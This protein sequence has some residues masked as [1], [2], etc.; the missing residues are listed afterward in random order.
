MIAS[1]H[2]EAAM[3]ETSK[4][5]KTVDKTDGKPAALA[6]IRDDWFVATCLA[7]SETAAVAALERYGHKAWRPQFVRWL[8][9]KKNRRR[10]KVYRELFPGYLFVSPL[11]EGDL[12]PAASDG[13]ELTGLAHAQ[14]L[15]SR[16]R[17]SRTASGVTEAGQWIK[18]LNSDRDASR[19]SASWILKLSLGQDAGDY[20]DLRN[21]PAPDLARGDHV[22]ALD[23]PFSALSG[24]VEMT[25]TERAR[26]AMTL[27]G[28]IVMVEAPVG[29][30]RKV[31]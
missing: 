13:A 17:R 27:F 31:A 21:A 28:R 1:F 5:W 26:F 25:N 16:S 12:V 18:W 10:V 29:A 22:K 23:G 3:N 9:D 20:D 14:G 2:Q 19:I 8:K 11:G 4:P 30:L 15:V 7:G 6:P 24:I